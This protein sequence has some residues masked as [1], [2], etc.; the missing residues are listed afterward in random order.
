VRP[1]LSR[2]LRLEELTP[3]RRQVG[4]SQLEGPRLS[5]VIT[6]S[7][8][9]LPTY[10]WCVANLPPELLL[11]SMARIR[12]HLTLSGDAINGSGRKRSRKLSPAGGLN[13]AWTCEYKELRPQDDYAV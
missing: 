2:A 4:S 9:E 6:G 8:C 13:R 5:A 11:T 10:F 12:R 3:P 7:I 1:S